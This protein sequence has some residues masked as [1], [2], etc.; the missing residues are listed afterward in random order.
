[1]EYMIPKQCA[2]VTSQ[3]VQHFMQSN[4][5]VYNIACLVNR[6]IATNMQ[7]KT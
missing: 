1:M 7:I 3:M 6:V 2:Q 4:Q 5:A